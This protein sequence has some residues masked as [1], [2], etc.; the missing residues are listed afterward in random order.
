MQA[1]KKE[2]SDFL[3]PGFS[4]CV[5]RAFA[6]IAFGVLVVAGCKPKSNFIENRLPLPP[7]VDSG[8]YEGQFVQTEYG[9]GFPV[10]AKW[11]YLRLSAD[12]EVDEVARFSDNSREV[13]LRISV[14]L[15]DEADKFSARDWADAAEQDLKSHQFK[16]KK[17]GSASDW[18]TAD[19]DR[20]V[21]VPFRL[22]DVKGNEWADEEWVLVKDD[23]LI[24]AHL[25]LPQKTADMEKGKKLVK[26]VQASLTQVHWYTPIGPRGISVERF[27]LRGFTE[28]FCRALESR[29]IPKIGSFFDEMY[30][31]RAKWNGW[32]QKAVAGDPV[33]FELKAELA[34]LVINGDYAYA[35]FALTRKDK[36]GPK[37]VKWER[38]FKL[39]KK[40]GSWEITGSMDKN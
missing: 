22:T 23:M 1:L 27:E 3:F 21:S 34:G 14:Q 20:W 17:R 16:I 4:L 29:S 13:I 38:N 18:K 26:A 25:T 2:K 40:E 24:G 30:P 36:S 9:F 35:S 6:V 11:N 19:S 12:Q 31:E 28:R 33:S 37:P 7:G 8:L 10:P 39:S 32:Y 15:R 5:L